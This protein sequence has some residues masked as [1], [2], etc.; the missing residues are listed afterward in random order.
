MNDFEVV[1]VGDKN[2]DNQLGQY[3]ITKAQQDIY[4]MLSGQLAD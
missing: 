3:R 2:Y 1:I 4:I